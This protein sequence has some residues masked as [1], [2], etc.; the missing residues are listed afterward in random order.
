MKVY[1]NINNFNAKNP[2]VAIGTFDGVH[3]GHRKIIERLKEIA[4]EKGGETVILTFKPHPRLVLSPNEKNLRLI[5]T[6]EEKITLFEEIGI[7]HLVVYPFTKGFASLSYADFVKKILVDKL[8]TSSLVI[9]YDH[10]F[11]KDRQGGFKYLNECA[12]KYGFS[13]EKQEAFEIENKSISSTKI[14]DALQDGNILYANKFLGY[15][16]SLNGSVIDGDQVGRKIGFPTANIKSSDVH[17]I[18]PGCGVYA[19]RASIEDRIYDG[20]LNI[21]TRPTF[22]ENADKR[23][24]EVHLFDFNE[25]IYNKDITLYFFQKIR[26]EKKFKSPDQLII[27]LKRDKKTVQEILKKNP[28]KI[29]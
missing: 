5:T 26:D 2:V 29:F 25:N 13:I 4:K 14:R 6:L 18:I 20:M 17:K 24:I 28:Y 10:R 3:L 22:N 9:G 7:E 8:Y 23:S 16:F 12:E 11:G 21:G 19:V 27:Q 15:T 1:Y